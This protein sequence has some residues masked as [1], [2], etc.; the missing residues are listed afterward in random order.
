MRKT[1]TQRF[2]G[3]PLGPEL[4][5]DLCLV[6]VPRVPVS[7]Q[8]LLKE[9]CDASEVQEETTEDLPALQHRAADSVRAASLS[10]TG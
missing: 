8:H 3:P 6:H 7:A 2:S 4:G 10:V 1:K 9:P 5:N